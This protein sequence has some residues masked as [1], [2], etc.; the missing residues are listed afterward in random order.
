MDSSTYLKASEVTEKKFPDGLRIPARIFHELS[1]KFLEIIDTSNHIDDMKKALIY[2]G[3]DTQGE[4]TIN[5]NQQQAEFLH[6]AMG[7]VTEVAEI[8][9]ALGP[10]LTVKDRTH[11]I[12]EMGDVKW[13]EAIF[14]RHLDATAEQVQAANIRKL[15]TRYPDKFNGFAALNR[16][17]D[18]ERASLES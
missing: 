15:A 3:V 18:A 11:F 2:K 7:M 14:L 4:A 5:L 16:N 1:D 12:E 13:Y 6:A 8:L 9:D 10:T 17:L